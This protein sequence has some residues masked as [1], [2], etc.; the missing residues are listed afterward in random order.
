MS[1]SFSEVPKNAR[2][3]GVYIEIDNSL[4][5]S[6]EQQQSILVIGNALVPVDG[7]PVTPANKVIL[8]MNKEVAIA[9]FGAGSDIAKMMNYLDKQKI[10][11][12]IY[13]I[14]VADADL[15]MALASLGDTQ[16]HHLI[17]ALN[18]DT[19][20]RELGEFLEARYDALSMIPGLAYVPKKGLHA[21]LVTFGAKSNCPLI[22]FMSINA[23]GDAAN[24]VLTDAE[25]LAAW[26]GQIAQSLANDPC[27]PLQT[28]VINGVYSMASSE[29]DW[30]ERNLLLHEGMSTYTV[31]ATGSVQVE[32]V[33]TAYT[34]NAAGVADDSYL[35]VMT[36][37]TAMYFREKQRSL[38][39][40]RYG[41][42]KL[43][44]DGTS[45][46][47]GQAIVTPSMVKS[48]LLTLYKALEYAGIV[49]D[50]EGYK[51]TLIAELDA[52]NKQRLNYQDS[53]QFVNGLIIVAGKIQFR[54]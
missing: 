47:Q 25:V 11:L 51:K 19:S 17:C 43:A 24:N 8:C 52:N 4:A 12:P 34:E 3:P 7:V 45:F 29:F 20:I 37:A 48:E 36:P 33:V 6:A 26:A 44:K 27:R 1:I 9:Q 42:H 30:S 38:I 49:Q 14:S 39:L 13:A 21:E 23:L 10:T 18:D 54:K 53:P 31:T 15:M 32:R 50:F 2:V 28:L 5:N 46:A 35:D 41:R 40:S 16:Y 22:S